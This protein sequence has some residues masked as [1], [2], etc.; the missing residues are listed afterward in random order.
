MTEHRRQQLGRLLAEIARAT[1][2]EIPRPNRLSSLSSQRRDTV[3]RIAYRAQMIQL[4][5]AMLDNDDGRDALLAL[6]TYDLNQTPRLGCL[7]AEWRF[8][9]LQAW[10]DLLRDEGVLHEGTE[11]RDSGAA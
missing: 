11:R 7:N 5:P 9:A 10:R 8:I 3:I 1:L 2:A 4:A 6:A